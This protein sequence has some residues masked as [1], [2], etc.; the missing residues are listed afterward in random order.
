MSKSKRNNAL[1]VFKKRFAT[2]LPE[3]YEAF[4]LSGSPWNERSR[5]IKVQDRKFNERFKFYKGA[6]DVICPYVLIENEEPSSPTVLDMNEILLSRQK[7]DG[8]LPSQCIGISSTETGEN[9]ILFVDGRR[10][11]EVWLKAWHR[12]T[13]D[14]MDDP[15][16][17]LYKLAS[18][19][20]SFMKAIDLPQ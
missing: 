14:N 15:E 3:E 10:K 13:H 11:G 18:S 6:V 17:D 16:E 12:L 4:L 20:A 5:E 19:F 7:G 9:I 2:W 1:R 8:L